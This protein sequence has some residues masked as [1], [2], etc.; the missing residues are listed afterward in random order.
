MI[1]DFF[2]G[3]W[4]VAR[5]AAWGGWVGGIRVWLGGDLGKVR[6]G[7]GEGG[8]GGGREKAL[9]GYFHLK[10]SHLCY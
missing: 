7:E 6:E 5:K 4:G 1:F 9:S 10:C 2:R 8:G 3:G